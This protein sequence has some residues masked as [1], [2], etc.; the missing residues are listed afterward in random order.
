MKIVRWFN[1]GRKTTFSF[2]FTGKESK[3]VIKTYMYLLD[4]LACDNDN[5][6]INLRIA[7][8][9]FA[10]L[11]LRNAVSRF[12]RVRVDEMVIGEVNEYCKCF[13]DCCSLLL[14]DVTPTVWTV[15]Y[16]IPYHYRLLY[17]KY[18]VGLGINATQGREAKHIKIQQFAGHSVHSTRWRHILRHE[19]ASNVW[20]R[21]QDKSSVRYIKHKVNEYLPPDHG[22]SYFL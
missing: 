11:Q 20:L 18:G 13:F 4:S 22:K 14:G 7:A 10:A 17:N 12:V 9:G 5:Q 19:Y 21:K 16:V 15:G 6:L 2:K 1:K 8:I 3:K